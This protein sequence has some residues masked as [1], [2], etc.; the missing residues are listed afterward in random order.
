MDFEDIYKLSERRNDYNVT[1]A[2]GSVDLDDVQD[3]DTNHIK[4]GKNRKPAIKGTP[5]FEYNNAGWKGIP[6]TGYK[7]KDYEAKYSKSG[8]LLENKVKISPALAESIKNYELKKSLLEN[9]AINKD[10]LHLLKESDDFYD[11][12]D[13]DFKEGDEQRRDNFERAMSKLYNFI[14]TEFAEFEIDIEDLMNEIDDYMERNVEGYDQFSGH[15]DPEDGYEAR[16]A[17]EW[18][19]TKDD[20]EPK[21]GSELSDEEWGEEF[22]DDEEWYNS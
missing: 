11:K 14:S 8:G 18:Q 3:G 13:A 16:V 17:S 15:Y 6:P 7:R 2:D 20:D 10:D 5:N 19:G 9:K 1:Y 12:M 22:S 4:S 21:L